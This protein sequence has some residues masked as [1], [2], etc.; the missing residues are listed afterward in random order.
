MKSLFINSSKNF[1]N[2]LYHFFEVFP[3]IT[4]IL[5]YID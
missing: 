5:T 2:S 4:G 1:N 3:N